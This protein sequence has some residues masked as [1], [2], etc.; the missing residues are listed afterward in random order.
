MRAT[1]RVVA[2][3]IALG[4]V[5]V[6]ARPASA[7]WFADLFV[8]PTFTRSEDVKIDGAAGRGTIRDVGFDTAVSGGV[9]FGRYFDAVPFLGVAVDGFLFY[10]NI[11]PQSARFDGCFIGVGGACGTRQ[12]GTGSFDISTAAISFDVMLR[13]PL[14]KTPEAPRGLVQPYITAGVPLFLTTIDPRNTRLFRNHD[15]ETDISIGYMAGGGV[16]IEVYKNL[17]LFAE[18]RF[19]HVSVDADLRDSVSAAKATFRTDL[20]SHSTLIG[21]SARW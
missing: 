11:A 14:F 8:G 1:R 9:R 20:N 3:V 6:G 18:Y 21:I 2:S 16:A 4:C 5:L 10:P 7:E 13:P 19:N 15:S 17:A 12:G